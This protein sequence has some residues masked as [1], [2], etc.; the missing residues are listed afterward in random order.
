MS[1]KERFLKLLDDDIAKYEESAKGWQALKDQGD[2]PEQSEN[3]IAR[4][5]NYADELKE[6][7]RKVATES[8]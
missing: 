8:I 5:R 2:F 7:R 1:D 6:L 4:S 3:L